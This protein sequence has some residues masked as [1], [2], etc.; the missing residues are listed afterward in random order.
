MKKLTIILLL[1]LYS[2]TIIAQFE[3]ENKIN[4]P[5]YY[6]SKIHFG[7]Y[8]EASLSNYKINLANN[9]RALGG[10]SLLTI[11]SPLKEAKG[12]NFGIISEWRIKKFGTLR[13]LPGLTFCK[14]IIEYDFVTSNDTFSITHN[15]ETSFFDIPLELKLNSNRLGNFAC[16]VTGGA[17]YSI[18]GKRS[19]NDYGFELSG[20]T[21]IFLRYFKF[22]IGIKYYSGVKNL[23][24]KNNTVFTQTIQSLL[25][26]SFLISFTFEG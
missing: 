20:G 12:F 5:D 17:K 15:S 23:L 11:R 24:V 9:W 18:G 21:D 8:T 3:T 14:R 6:N 7:F 25:S 2:S 4:L 22:G 19:G 1:L 13:F 10:D 16:Y 26:R